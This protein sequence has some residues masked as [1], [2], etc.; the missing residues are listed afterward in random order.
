MVVFADGESYV[1]CCNTNYESENSGDLAIE[2]DDPRYDEFYQS[3]MEV[4]DNPNPARN[5]PEMPSD[6]HR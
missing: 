5:R 2:M 4:C 1:C 3:A 6:L